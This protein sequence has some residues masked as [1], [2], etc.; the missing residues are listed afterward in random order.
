VVLVI[1]CRFFP[2]TPHTCLTLL[3]LVS[4]YQKRENRTLPD[5]TNR[6][7]MDISIDGVPAGKVV[8]GLFGKIAPKAVE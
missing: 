6:V 7:Y 4:F 3:G 8:F 1:S 5:I 2:T